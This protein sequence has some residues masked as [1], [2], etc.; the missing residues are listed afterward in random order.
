MFTVVTQK[1]LSD[2][3]RYFQEHLTRN[4]YYTAEEMRPG[5]WIGLGAQRLGL[6]TTR[7][8]FCEEFE[9]L[10]ENKH[11]QTGERLTLRQNEKD[12]RRV[13]YDF[14]CS[15]P[16]SVSVLAVT[17]NDERLVIAHEAAVE[18]AFRELEGFAATR[19]RKQ[20]RQLDRNTGNLL[21]A[22]FTHAGRNLT[23]FVQRSGSGAR[24]GG[25]N[26]SYWEHQG[27]A[28]VVWF[29]RAMK[30]ATRTCAR[31]NFSPP[32]RTNCARRSTPSSA[33]RV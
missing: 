27:E 22:R 23:A 3:K 4:D 12:N 33:G 11:P 17:L 21:A 26:I 2:A 15:A 16:K 6:D 9:R 10:C 13:F 25:P 29:G 8:V 24:Y 30:C 1:N 28:S 14:T 5:Q 7:A 31:T 19:V 20:G 18:A 32:S